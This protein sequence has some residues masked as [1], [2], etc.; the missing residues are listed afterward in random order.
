MPDIVLKSALF[1]V[2]ENV[3]NVSA[4]TLTYQDALDTLNGDFKGDPKVLQLS[5]SLIRVSQAVWAYS[6]GT[7]TVV[8]YEM[9]LSGSGIGPV[10]TLNG[11]MDAI[12][13]GLAAGTLSKL[14][15]L[16]GTTSILALT[17]DTAGYHLTSGD[18]TVTLAGALPLSFTQ[19]ADVA[20]LFERVANLDLLNDA[21]RTA[22]FNDLSAYSATGLTLTEAGHVLFDVHVG[23][24]AASLTFNGLTL[25][26]TGTF[27]DNFGEDVQV[28]W[29]LFGAASSAPGLAVTGFAGLSIT[30]LTLTDAAGR[31]VG[32]VAD[33]MAD[34]PTV[35][36]VDGRIYELVQM[37]GNGNDRMEVY[38]VHW[39]NQHYFDGSTVVA[40][41]G[42]RDKLIG[43]F[44]GDLLLGGTGN[45]TML[46]NDGNDRLDGGKGRD[47]MTGGI[48][49]DVFRFDLG[50]GTDRITDFH[51]G[52]DVIQILD[53]SRKSDLTFTVMGDNVQIDY[54]SIH[55]LVEHIT[56][57]QLDQPGNFQF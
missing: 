35:T 13:G 4:L 20:H 34:T 33:P 43:G 3:L 10:S 21:D 39:R 19:F 8:T 40:G 52:E 38:D 9:R 16:Q 26:L 17:M 31:V 54:R 25:S 57:A 32:S 41:L 12:N 1:D 27:P 28:L 29:N 48:G 23:A 42:G 53:A 47:V 56:L 51:A 7:P 2:L 14:E 5:A 22:L 11:L 45:D 46:G 24:T 55:I 6:T 37:G 15:I 50:D 49:A 30:G 36:K 44:K 18:I